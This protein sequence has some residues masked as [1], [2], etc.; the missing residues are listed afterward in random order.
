MCQVRTLQSC[1]CRSLASPW[2]LSPYLW[3][4]KEITISWTYVSSRVEALR[5]PQQCILRGF[6]PEWLLQYTL[7]WF[8]SLEQKTPSSQGSYKPHC[9]FHL[10]NPPYHYRSS[11]H[12]HHGHQV[13]V[14]WREGPVWFPTVKT[15]GL[16]RQCWLRHQETQ[17]KDWV[18]GTQA[19]SWLSPPLSIYPLPDP[20]E[21]GSFYLIFSN[22]SLEWETWHVP[23]IS[24]VPAWSELLFT[25]FTEKEVGIPQ[26]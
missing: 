20:I 15:L 10:T 12:G 25:H 19:L 24:S 3:K 1:P 17:L 11:H 7:P 6:P 2:I 22:T 5:G 26:A 8:P 21:F 23:G 16:V 9:P 13:W 14:K 4:K 18:H